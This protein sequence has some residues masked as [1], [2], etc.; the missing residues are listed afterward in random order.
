[1]A[2]KLDGYTVSLLHF[3]E[4]LTDE[5]GKVWQGRNG[6]EVST[7]Q[8]KF[9]GKSLSLNGITGYLTSTES[10]D[11]DL[12]AVD[13]TIDWWEYRT[14]ITERGMAASIGTDA[15]DYHGMLV[16]F[17]KDGYVNF[18][19]SFTGNTWGLDLFKLGTPDLNKWN[20]FAI[21]RSGD[22][23]Y[24]F[25][26]GKLTTTATR[27]GHIVNGCNIARIG[28][29][30]YVYTAPFYFQG[31]IDEFRISKGIARWTKDFDPEAVEPNSL[32]RI[33]MN[34]S[35]ERE[36]IV[37][38]SVA[39]AFIN[40]CNRPLGTGN[41]CYIFNKEIQN[42]KEYLFYEKIISFELIPIAE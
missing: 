3:D 28:N 13:F 18:N 2:Y 36:Y 22:V 4:G 8:A 17:I 23:F 39:D 21:V 6:A 1:M 37:T 24:G 12:T 42:K 33:T 7:S 10:N 5:A 35:S 19:C 20:H 26:N 38:Q 27:A 41:S 32:L 25:K 14:S 34:D 40:W 16:G 30:N 11:F 31:Y 15:D 29:W 9:G